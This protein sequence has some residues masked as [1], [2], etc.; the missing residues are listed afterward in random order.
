MSAALNAA[1]T[2]SG[3]V[4]HYDDADTANRRPH[5]ATSLDMPTRA[6]LVVLETM[7]LVSGRQDP[8][9]RAPRRVYVV[10][11]EER[12]KAGISDVRQV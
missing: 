3:M 4:N 9:S 2:A 12:R 11:G 10:T 8:D 7:R 5:V 1:T 6:H